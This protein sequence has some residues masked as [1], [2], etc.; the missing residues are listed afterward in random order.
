MIGCVVCP[1]IMLKAIRAPTV[2]RPPIT[3]SAPKN[4][5]R[6]VESLVVN[7]TA[8]CPLAPIRVA[9][10]PAFT[11]SEKRLSHSFWMSGSTAAAFRV[12]MPTRLSMMN[13]WLWLQRANFS[14]SLALR[15][16]R[17]FSAI[18]R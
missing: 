11:Y 16:G 17:I 4:R 9:S 15:P 2:M 10:K 6:D 12:W 18:S 5:I 1:A 7:S 14:L 3:S 8:V 13:C